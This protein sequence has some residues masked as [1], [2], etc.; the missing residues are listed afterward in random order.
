MAS[1]AREI[2]TGDPNQLRPLRSN[3]APDGL[4]GLSPTERKR[5]ELA[6]ILYDWACAAFLLCVR[7]GIL[8]TLENPNSSLFWLTSFYKRLL[9]VFTPYSGIFQAC[10]YGS[11]RPKW[12]RI[13]ASF[14]EI[15]RLSVSCD[16][17]HE[18]AAWGKTYHPDTGSEVWATSLEAR[19]PQKLCVA[20]RML[21]Y[22]FC[23]RRDCSLYLNQS[24]PL[25]ILHC[26]VRNL[27][28][29]T[30]QQT[31]DFWQDSTID[32]R[33]LKWL[34]YQVMKLFQCL[35]SPNYKKRGTWMLLCHCQQDPDYSDAHEKLLGETRV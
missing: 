12:T 19:Y 13:I 14:Q 32:C 24:V 26:I 35:C 33:F 7:T 3:E 8:A 31:R 21:S 10:M 23:I 29:Y 25:Q 28:Q 1:R 34:L 2:D 11:S 22:K 16:N 30:H 9:E 27:H 18:H 4:P 5:V 17:N 15:Q 20:V 6:N